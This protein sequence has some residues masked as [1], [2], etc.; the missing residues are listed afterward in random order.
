MNLD[1][2]LGNV[3]SYCLQ[4]GVL[5]GVA[6]FLPALLRI[7]VPRLRLAFWHTLLAACLLLPLL[8][9]WRR[10][11]VTSGSRVTTI[12]ITPAAPVRP[13][14]RRAIAWNQIALGLLCAGIRVR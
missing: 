2:I 9:P 1:L 12:R 13:A 11:V 8:A 7:S 3:A 14:P 5:V 4:I 6:A 10:D